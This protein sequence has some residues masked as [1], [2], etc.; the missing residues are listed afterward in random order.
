MCSPSLV[1]LVNVLCFALLLLLFSS[2]KDK[3]T[4]TVSTAA[5]VF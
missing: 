1:T 4:L 5:V 2:W 3:K